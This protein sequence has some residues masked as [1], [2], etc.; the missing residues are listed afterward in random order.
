LIFKK[1]RK[2]GIVLPNA[3][4]TSYKT[5]IKQNCILIKK[6]K[7]ELVTRVNCAVKKAVSIVVHIVIG[8]RNN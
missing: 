1:R 5:L 2:T 4:K 6:R 8:I 3:N 7:T